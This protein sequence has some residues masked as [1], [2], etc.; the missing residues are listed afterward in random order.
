MTS[1]PYSTDTAPLAHTDALVLD[2]L[3]AL[4]AATDDL[5]PEL[6]DELMTTVADYIA[7][8][9]S[10]SGGPVEDPAQILRRLGSPESLAAAARR[11]RVPAHLRRPVPAPAVPAAPSS[12]AEYAGLALLTAGAVVLPV[13]GP[14][15][16]MLLISG[17]PRWSAAH[18]TAAWVLAAGPALLGF[19]LVVLAVMLGGGPDTLVVAYLMT[20]AG[21]FVAA[22][23]LL[24]GLS[25]RR[26][27][28]PGY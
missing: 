15:A 2:Y 9:R 22:L 4:W 26:H 23:C 19:A 11:G 7:L 8:R 25:A 20:L 6:R 12:G 5:E 1:G 10:V 17:S 14:F 28:P 13:L 3:A 16:G 21:G 27:Y 24:P 18:K